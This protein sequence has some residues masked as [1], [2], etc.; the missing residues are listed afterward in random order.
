MC[1]ETF[2]DMKSLIEHIREKSTIDRD[3]ELLLT[4]YYT[5]N[6]HINSV[7]QSLFQD[8]LQEIRNLEKKVKSMKKPSNEDIEDVIKTIERLLESIP[9]PSDPLE[10]SIYESIVSKIENI[11]SWRHRTKNDLLRILSSIRS[12]FISG[13]KTFNTMILKAAMI[14]SQK[15]FVKV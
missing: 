11:L 13:R 10:T 15:Y 5:L 7:L 6:A 14:L 1:K 9:E 8:F 4:A 3:H 12:I 2:E